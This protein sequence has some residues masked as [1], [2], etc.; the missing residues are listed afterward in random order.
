MTGKENY[1]TELR[2]KTCI[3]LVVRPETVVPSN[4]QQ[5][6]ER[7]C[8]KR[9]ESVWASVANE[10]GCQGHDFCATRV[11]VDEDGLPA[12]TAEDTAGIVRVIPSEELGT[13]LKNDAKKMAKDNAWACY[14][15][16]F[17]AAAALNI[18]IFCFKPKVWVGLET[19]LLPIRFILANP[20]LRLFRATTQFS[21]DA[22]KEEFGGLLCSGM[23]VTFPPF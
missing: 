12:G 1:A 16:V 7:T 2:V 21:Y 20:L 13:L 18:D 22:E 15:W 17:S 8:N 4:I 3:N 9:T 19:H 10:C 5:Q 23:T 14:H 6:N 11:T